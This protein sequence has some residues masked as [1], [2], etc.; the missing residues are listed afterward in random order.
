ML[1][2]MKQ[3][4]GAEFHLPYP[5]I[6]NCRRNGKALVDDTALWT[7]QMGIFFLPLVNM[8]CMTAQRWERLIY[9][10]GGA[11]NLL[12]CLW[13]GVQWS[14]TAAELPKMEKIKDD[15]PVITLSSG[16]DFNKITTFSALKQQK[17]CAPS[18]YVWH[19]IGAILKSINADWTRQP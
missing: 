16:A 15:D 7:V 6:K 18:V 3:A 1:D 14:F 13:Y 2:Q 4:E 11:L 5:T 8:M 19:L 17:G 10:T 9:A 12:K